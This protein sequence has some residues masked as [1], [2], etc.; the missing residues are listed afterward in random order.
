MDKKID[1]RVDLP[2]LSD[3]ELM[4]QK[5]DYGTRYDVKEVDKRIAE[6]GLMYG[7]AVLAAANKDEEIN[8]LKGRVT[9][10]TIETDRIAGLEAACAEQERHDRKLFEDMKGSIAELEEENRR[11]S[12]AFYAVGA[13]L[14]K[15]PC[16]GMA[17]NTDSCAG[18]CIRCRAVHAFLEARWELKEKQ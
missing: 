18:Q 2:K 17:E 5:Y 12:H 3:L 4:M 13:A 11:L 10:L 14:A 6:L 7:Q 8:T 1:D 16:D 9:D 15:L